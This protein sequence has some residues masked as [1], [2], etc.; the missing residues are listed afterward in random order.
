MLI[1]VNNE[2]VCIIVLHNTTKC[3]K[4]C[5]I[6]VVTIKDYSPKKITHSISTN[7]P[8]ILNYKARKFKCKD[9]GK[10]FLEANSFCHKDEKISLYTDIK[11]MENLRSH[12]S[13]FT[14]V[15]NS[16]ILEAG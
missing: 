7:Q 4:E 10:I 8:C 15:T 2:L 1:K 11:I 16:L 14:S 12:T 9:C 6:T 3:W 5:G 13:T